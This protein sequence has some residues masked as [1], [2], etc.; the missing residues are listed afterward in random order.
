MKKRLRSQVIS[1]AVVLPAVVAVL[2]VMVCSS[3][4]FGIGRLHFAIVIAAVVHLMICVWVRDHK[5][6]VAKLA[7]LAWLSILCSGS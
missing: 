2:A 3:S 5:P 1:L 4:F 6:L 7:V